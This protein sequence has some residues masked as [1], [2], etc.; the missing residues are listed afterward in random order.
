A[1]GMKDVSDGFND[2][3]LSHRYQEFNQQYIEAWYFLTLHTMRFC[4]GFCRQPEVRRWRAPLVVLDIDGV[5]DKQIFGFPST[6]AAGIRAVSLLHAHDFAVMVNTAR[7]MT[8]VKAYCRAYGFVG[9]V[10][11]YGGAVWDAV[12]GREQILVSPESLDQIEMVKSALRQI[13]GVFLSDLYR[14]SIRAY[15]YERGTTVPL[16][17]VLIR[18]LMARLKPT[19]LSFH[20]TFTDTTILAKEVDKCKGLLELLRLVGQDNVETLAV[21][22]SEPDL[23]MFQVAKRCFAPS[24][25]SCRAIAKLLGCQIS[26]RPFQTGLLSIVY[27]LI[28]PDG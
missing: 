10:A 17:T 23:A 9:G 16:P 11:D 15:T 24:H 18:S 27:S 25:I 19:R 4:A 14:H 26:D 5:L 21:G 8:E 7:P 1:R 12:S 28:H 13:P 20:Q 2:P 6:T 3:R 22:D